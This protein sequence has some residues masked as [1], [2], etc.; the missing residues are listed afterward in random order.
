MLRFPNTLTCYFL[1]IK[2]IAVSRRKK[3]ISPTYAFLC[4]LLHKRIRHLLV[5]SIL[6]AQSRLPVRNARLDSSLCVKVLEGGSLGL[7]VKCV[8][9]V[10]VD[11]ELLVNHCSSITIVP[12]ELCRLMIV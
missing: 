8:V 5:H 11:P 1:F 12:R 4:G 2:I 10:V 9:E 6:F 3:N 7:H